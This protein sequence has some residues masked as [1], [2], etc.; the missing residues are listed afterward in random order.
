MGKKP[1]SKTVS[2]YQKWVA[3]KYGLYAGTF[4]CPTIPATIVTLI[5]WE[6]WFGKSNISLPFGFAC[7]L[8]TV[9]VAVLGVLKSDTVFKKADI[10]LYYLSGMFMCIGLTCLFLAS[11][12]SQMGYLWLYTASGLLGSGVCITV[13]KK[14]FEPRIAEY[15]GLIDEFTLDNKARRKKAR[16][17]RA[18][19]EA[20]AEA[21]R[22]ATE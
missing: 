6:E 4:A 19:A 15:K 14:V 5:N 13:E 16:M 11:L 3:G 20:E 22:Q 10:A 21:S 12:F 9:I 7:L 2:T 18:R 8:V 17:E 1:K